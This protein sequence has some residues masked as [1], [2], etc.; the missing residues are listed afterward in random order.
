MPQVAGP[1]VNSRPSP[2]APDASPRT[3][4]LSLSS[5]SQVRARLESLPVVRPE[6][7]EAA[8]SLIVSPNYPPLE[9]I[10]RIA[11]ALLNAPDLTESPENS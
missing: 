2:Q 10:R 7:V 3:D 11:D 9:I 6:K 5:A 1:S 8:K 4:S